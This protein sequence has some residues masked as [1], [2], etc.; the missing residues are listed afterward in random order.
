MRDHLP[1]GLRGMLVASFLAAYM[2]TIST[3]LNWGTSYVM[4][5]FYRRFINPQ[6]GE[7]ALVNLSRVMTVVLMVLSLGVTSI[8]DTISGAWAFI[9]EAGA[10]LGLVLILRWYWWRINAWSEIAAMVTPLVV[11]GYL[12]AFTTVAF[13][14]TLYVIVGI[15]T[16]AWLA[17]TFLTPPTDARHAR[18]LLPSR[19]PRRAGLGAGRPP[20]ARRAAGHRPGAPARGHDRRRR[21]RVLHAVRVGQVALRQ[22][23]GGARLPRGRGRRRRRH[24]PRPVPA[25]VGTLVD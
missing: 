14:Q 5:D 20:R 23:H 17:V 1:P 22:R 10:G 8:L 4:N 25:R 3:Q 9:I 16:V 18:R 13:P 11:Y 19:A 2:S 15:T 7:K 21:P 24:L 12:R 6:A